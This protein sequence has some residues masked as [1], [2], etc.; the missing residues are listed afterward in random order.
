MNVAYND[1]IKKEAMVLLEEKNVYNPPSFGGVPLDTAYIAYVADGVTFRFAYWN[2]VEVEPNNT[3]RRGKTFFRPNNTDLW[4]YPIQRWRQ[5][6]TSY[7]NAVTAHN[8]AQS[9]YNTALSAYNGLSV[10]YNLAVDNLPPTSNL[11]KKDIC[12]KRLSSCKLR[13]GKG[14]QLPFGGFPGVGL[15]T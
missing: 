2:G 4:V 5:N 12:G 3:Y 8:T 10:S 7:N 13:F 1:M 11:Y 15:T 14:A 6:T 9:E